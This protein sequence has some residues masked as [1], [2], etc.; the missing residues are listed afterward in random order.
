MSITGSLVGYENNNEITITKKTHTS[1]STAIAS[2]NR[3]LLNITT[4]SG[5][6]ITKPCPS[7]NSSISNSIIT[8]ASSNLSAGHHQH[9]QHQQNAKNQNM[10]NR[11]SQQKQQQQ[12]KSYH[13]KQL[14]GHHRAG[15]GGIGG[16]QNQDGGVAVSHLHLNSLW[17]IWYGILVTL[18]Q[19]Y[20]AVHG[21]Y[22]FLGC[23]L[24]QWKIEPII[25]L[26]IQ[27]VICGVVFI[28][29]PLFF[30]S[31]VFKVGNLAND[32]IKLG[33]M[34]H[35]RCSISPHDGLEEEAKGG[36]VRALWTHGGPTAAFVHI[37]IALCL[38]LPRLLLEARIIENGLLPRENIWRNEL[39]F[40]GSNRE[41]L[42]VMSFTTSPYQNRTFGGNDTNYYWDDDNST[43][44]LPQKN[45]GHVYKFYPKLPVFE[46]E[47]VEQFAPDN[48]EIMDSHEN[49]EME[50]TSSS[51]TPMKIVK[52]SKTT[53]TTPKITPSISTTRTA[54]SIRNESR[55][56]GSRSHRKQPHKSNKSSEE[57][58]SHYK[59]ED[60]NRSLELK[61]EKF[62]FNNFKDIELSTVFESTSHSKSH[63][64]TPSTKKH[65][66][67]LASK[68]TLAPKTT[69]TEPT[70]VRRYTQTTT[71][72]LTSL[73]DSDIHIVKPERLPEIIPSTPIA[74]NSKIIEIKPKKV[75]KRT[76]MDDSADE[77]AVIVEILPEALIGAVQ[78]NLSS[79]SLVKLDG[80]SGVLQRFFGIEKPIDT[81][82]FSH[83]PSME[84]LNLVVAMIVW[85]VRYPA[86]F[87]STTKSFATVFSIQMVA[88]TVDIILSYVGV[89]TLYKLQ[90]VGNVL[91]THTP[92]LLLNAVVTLS[93]FLLS[94]ILII[95]SSLILYLYGHGRLAARMR[96]RC[97]I[98]VKNSETWIYFAHCAS[99][100]LVLALAVVKAPLMHD[101]SAAYRGSLDNSILCSALG[102]VIHLFLWIVIWLGLT[103]KRRWSFKLPPLVQYGTGSGATQ[104]LLISTR[105]GGHSDSKGLSTTSSTDGVEDT[106]YWPKMTPNS[107]KLKVTFNEVTSTS[108]DVLIIGEHDGKRCT[109]GGTTICITSVTG[110]ADDG[111]YATLRAGVIQGG[112]CPLNGVDGTTNG[113]IGGG[114]SGGSILHLSE[115]DELPPP[116][117]QLLPL[118]SCNT[119][120]GI[121]FVDDN[122]S[123][124]GKLLA[125]VRDDSVTYASTRD[126]EPPQPPPPPTVQSPIVAPQQHIEVMHLGSP[127]DLVSPLAPV[128]VTVH[129][130]EAHETNLRSRNGKNIWLN[131]NV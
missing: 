83:P 90:I 25:E 29:L 84:F 85:S 19:G 36:T 37:V 121:D 48:S 26:N 71:T 24:V 61:S 2:T 115:Y 16:G 107:P 1:S 77:D 56:N 109:T 27:I 9:H 91:P 22:R 130:N 122:T 64:T 72:R 54:K 39:D 98:T 116:P 101:L 47:A 20:L 46:S 93:L 123:E 106:I 124:E 28:L 79:Y 42:V 51:A 6:S 11:K 108:E 23:S 43:S 86:V 67:S 117:E 105:D 78:A 74:T 3:S 119:V 120:N 10:S 18:F 31:A 32:G 102:S 38:L 111:D 65:T 94:T 103:A 95:A 118:P 99:L 69:P 80:F 50:P 112:G 96:D 110:E 131:F 62:D 35:S 59:L 70:M 88:N 104:P 66:S 60:V 125:C 55:K 82:S 89:S 57:K 114:P 15:G 12:H 17:S 7:L 129:T 128:T 52:H 100:C 127:V 44:H 63:R 126:L 53:A 75:Q 97:M 40:L 113:I 58:R 81:S 33:T 4:T 68:A 5:G 41:R 34:A 87:W 45:I 14:E 21:A 76:I 8:T 30:A 49:L 92:G 13:Q 73:P